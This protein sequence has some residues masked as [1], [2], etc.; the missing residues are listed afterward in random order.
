MD[1]MTFGQF[2]VG[3]REERGFSQ[4]KLAEIANITNSTVSRIES[5]QVKPDPLTLEKLSQ[6]LSVEK[7]L[8]MTKCGYSE[9]PEDFVVIARKTGEVKEQQREELFNLLNE[10]IDSFLA[11]MD[12]D[13]KEG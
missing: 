2:L 7:S 10:T 4:R 13:N 5:N 8:L 3:L 1:K 6:A 12:E 9:I 11:G